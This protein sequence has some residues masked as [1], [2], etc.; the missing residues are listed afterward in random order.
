[1]NTVL[2]C[3][4]TR[5]FIYTTAGVK[6]IFDG[7]LGKVERN[8]KLSFAAKRI[9]RLQI[10]LL[11]IVIGSFILPDIWCLMQGQTIKGEAVIMNT[12][13]INEWRADSRYMT[14]TLVETNSVYRCHVIDVGFTE[15]SPI[16]IEILPFSMYAGRVVEKAR[17]RVM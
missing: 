14:I 15:G 9:V 2:M 12:D 1:M 13:T 16:D 7:L 4:I 10:G 17:L 3:T 8:S 5:F 6:L 11:G